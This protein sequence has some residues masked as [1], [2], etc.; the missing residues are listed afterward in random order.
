[1]TIEHHDLHHEFPEFKE[2]IHRLKLGNQ[3]FAH[4]FDEY[5]LVTS[6][7]EKLEG[8]GVPVS[9][10]AFESAK[11]ARLKLKDEL[12]AMLLANQAKASH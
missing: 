4:L 5:H 3:H 11:K 2:T 10:A 9:D 8:M 6:E 1:M 7:V 12:Y